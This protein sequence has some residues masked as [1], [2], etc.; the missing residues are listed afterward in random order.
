MA[1]F[2]R[3]ALSKEAKQEWFDSWEFDFVLDNETGKLGEKTTIKLNEIL[4]IDD[5]FFIENVNKPIVIRSGIAKLMKH[6]NITEESHD[7]DSLPYNAI[8]IVYCNMELARGG[9]RFLGNGEASSANLDPGIAASY[10][11]AMAIKRARSRGVLDMIGLDAYGE[12]ESP[13]FKP[14]AEAND[15]DVEF[16]IRQMLSKRIMAALSNKESWV[17]AAKGNIKNH[18]KTEKVDLKD[19]D[20]GQLLDI[21]DIIA[22]CR[23]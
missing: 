8:N 19:Y 16:K 3:Q 21:L 1:K 20:S 6:F 12:D 10:P 2:K 5:I 11:I 15:S 7:I 14:S 22:V 4:G 13:D 17:D 9:V 18:L 23:S